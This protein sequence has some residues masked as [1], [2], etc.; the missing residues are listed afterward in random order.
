MTQQNRIPRKLESIP[1]HSCAGIQVKNV[2]IDLGIVVREGV[3]IH[4]H[5]H[6]VSAFRILQVNAFSL[7][8]EGGQRKWT[9]THLGR[10]KHGPIRRGF[11]FCVLLAN[12]CV[13]HHYRAADTARKASTATI[14]TID[15]ISHHSH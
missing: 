7:K 3:V 15:S 8:K 10:Y 2:A 6:N 14:I 11:A 13:R 12:F 5:I 1:C 9:R 4:S